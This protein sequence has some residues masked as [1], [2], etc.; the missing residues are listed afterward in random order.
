MKSWS[1]L[2]G[3]DLPPMEE[4]APDHHSFLMTCI[5]HIPA[6]RPSFATSFDLGKEV[7]FTTSTNSD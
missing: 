6:G 4:M 7:E 1:W 5:K 3:W 2:L